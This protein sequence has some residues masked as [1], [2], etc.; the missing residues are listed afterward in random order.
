MECWERSIGIAIMWQNWI[1]GKVTIEQF[2]H[3]KPRLK[4]TAGQWANKGGSGWGRQ[5]ETSGVRLGSLAVVQVKSEIWLEDLYS[6]TESGRASGSSGRVN[7]SGI[8]EENTTLCTEEHHCTAQEDIWL[9]PGWIWWMVLL[10]CWQWEDIQFRK[11]WKF[12][13]I[14]KYWKQQIQNVDDNS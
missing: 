12:W 3:K 10:W 4:I 13:R 1:Q 9:C 11:K 8:W 7:Y 5:T 14:W 6:L 2:F